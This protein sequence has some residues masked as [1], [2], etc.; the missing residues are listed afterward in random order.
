MALV[1]LLFGILELYPIAGASA[2]LVAGA[3]GWLSFQDFDVRVRRTVH[4]ARV[5]A[6]M[7]A[8]VEL[9]VRNAGARTSPPISASDPFDGGKKWARFAVAP[10]APGEIRVASY[11]LPTGRRGIYRLGP[12]ELEVTDPFGMARIIRST[13][14]DASLTVHPRIEPLANR[15]I[16]ARRDQE[17]RL[18]QPVLGQG[19]NEF[20][21]LRQYMTGDDLRH[22]HWPS[23]ARVDD[24]IIR[25]PENVWRGRFLLAV[26]LR[27]RV[28][29]RESVERVLS[30]IASLATAAIAAGVQVRVV[31]T[32]G[33][34]S[35]YVSSTAKGPSILDAL[36]AASPHPGGSLPECLRMLRRPEPLIAVTTDSCDEEDLSSVIRLSGG[37]EATVVI[38]E[39]AG[40][41]DSAVSLSLA[42][43]ARLVRVPRGASFR[44]A[45]Q[46][47]PC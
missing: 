30:A 36:A 45:W 46:R 34:D 4:P 22:V 37:G 27:S 47:L 10:L 42:G 28:H 5:P 9:T 17:S 29:D 8:R 6:G 39:R 7:E 23:T 19:G 40:G 16:F 43:W 26:D 20:Y 12:L 38:F 31:S 33:F 15:A 14:P 11:R 44:N 21:G 25:Q 3:W 24:L 13:T 1:A 18:P 2:M 32:A 35:G 41:R